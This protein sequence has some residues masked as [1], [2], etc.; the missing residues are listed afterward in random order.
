VKSVYIIFSILLYSLLFISRSSTLSKSSCKKPE[1]SIRFCEVLE[2]PNKPEIVTA[3]SD[4]FK[5]S[6]VQSKRF[7]PKTKQLFF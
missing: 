4:F 2:V 3:G 1:C 6:L 5:T 7:Y